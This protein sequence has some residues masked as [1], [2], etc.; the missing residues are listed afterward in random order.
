MVLSI[1]DL[2]SVNISKYI[3]TK[4]ARFVQTLFIDLKYNDQETPS[5]NKIQ[6]TAKYSHLGYE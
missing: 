5:A 4:K 2:G 1:A 3:Q 6:V